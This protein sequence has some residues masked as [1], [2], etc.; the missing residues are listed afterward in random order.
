MF[1]NSFIFSFLI[2]LGLILQ[3]QNSETPKA[4]YQT[5]SNLFVFYNLYWFNMHHFLYHE[6]MMNSVADST[7]IGEET[8]G[9]ISKQESKVLD[10]AIDFYQ[11]D[12]AD[13][14]LRTS[15]YMKAFRKWIIRH[16]NLPSSIP[17][18]F[19]SHIEMLKR[20]DPIYKKYFWPQHEASNQQILR[21]NLPLIE[22]TEDSAAQWLSILTR[23]YWQEEKI[24]ID[25]VYFGKASADNWRHRPY[26]SL[27]PTHIVMNS[28]EAPNTPHGNWIE[29]L[30]HEASHHLIGGNY[31]FV[32]GTIQDITKV[33]GVR[34]SR[35][36]WHAYL[37]YFSGVVT[38]ELLT[39]QGIADY[40]MYMVRYRVFYRYFP[41]LEKH[42]FPYI[43]REVTL[44]DATKELIEDLE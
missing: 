34:G 18:K 9:K 42:L 38:K 24:R 5:Q 23:Q 7:V 43:E 21:K 16:E 27:G 6:A 13:R 40:T 3:A 37:F 15:E 25:L 1:K 36:L 19:S 32:G 31:G 14:D 2:S 44:H 20:F 12:L 4:G 30:Y 17:S 11:T 29:L 39:N 10:D 35:S 26:T 8:L 22:R 41:L 33:I 28:A